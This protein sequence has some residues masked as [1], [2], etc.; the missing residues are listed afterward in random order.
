MKKTLIALMLVIVTAL[1]LVSCSGIFD[2]DETE[3]PDT[4]EV[5]KYKQVVMESTQLDIMSVR[6]IIFDKIGMIGFVLDYEPAEK[7]EIVIGDTNRPVTALAK[8]ELEKI[9]AT[10]KDLDVGYIIYSDGNSVAVYWQDARLASVA[11]ST[12]EAKLLKS[13]NLYP[14]AGMIANGGYTLKALEQERKEIKQQMAALQADLDDN[15]DEISHQVGFADY[16]TFYRAFKKEYGINPR[17]YRKLQTAE[18]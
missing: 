6:S 15:L 18:Y 10:K 7:Y 16:S 13:G 5:K 4:P 14:D 2:G 1:T 8:A 12:L 17:Q 9:M 3:T 11:L